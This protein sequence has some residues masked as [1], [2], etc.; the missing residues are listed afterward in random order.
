MLRSRLTPTLQ[1]FVASSLEEI[2]HTVEK[3]LSSVRGTL[4]IH[5]RDSIVFR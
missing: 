3:E 5:F 2:D 4:Y 1:A